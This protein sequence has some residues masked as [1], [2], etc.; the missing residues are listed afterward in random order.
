MTR[1]RQDADMGENFGM[2]KGFESY[3]DAHRS[4]DVDN[5]RESLHHTLGFDPTQ[6]APGDV[7]EKML[8]EVATLKQ[9]LLYA[10]FFKYVSGT[11]SQANFVTSVAGWT[12]DSWIL[13]RVGDSIQA[14]VTVT[15]SGGA[16]T[17]P[18]NGNI[19][20]QQIATVNTAN[21]SPG[22]SVSGVSASAGRLCNGVFSSGGEVVI[23]AM[24]PG[25][26]VANGE[27]FQVQAM[28]SKPLTDNIYNA[29][30]DL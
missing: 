15:R 17:V 18:V 13:W 30:K 22:S 10:R 20:N 25:A 29:I 2:T 14:T 4:S 26:N 7:V 5:D 3:R 21:W 9:Q 6:A 23:A 24:A 28:Y 1:F 27:Q 19:G 16:I 8:K 11:T 12:L